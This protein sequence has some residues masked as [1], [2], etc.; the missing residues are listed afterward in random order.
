MQLKEWNLVKTLVT[1]M[2]E[3]QEARCVGKSEDGK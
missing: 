2:H 3:L 1:D